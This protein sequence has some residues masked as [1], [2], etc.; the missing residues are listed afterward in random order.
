MVSPCMHSSWRRSVHEHASRHSRIREHGGMNTACEGV[1]SRPPVSQHHQELLRFEKVAP[2][3]PCP[4]LPFPSG[5][6]C[7]TARFDPTPVIRFSSRRQDSGTWTADNVCECLSRFSR[8]T[9]LNSAQKTFSVSA[10]PVREP[11]LVLLLSLS[12]GGFFD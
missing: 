9:Q 10:P 4:V 3:A 11:L 8:S 7:E 2:I 12:S 5:R 1:H 6:N